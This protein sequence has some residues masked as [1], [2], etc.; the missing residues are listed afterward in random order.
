MNSLNFPHYSIH[1]TSSPPSLDELLRAHDSIIPCRRHKKSCVSS[2][3]LT[4]TRLT[5]PCPPAPRPLPVDGRDVVAPDCMTRRSEGREG[6][7]RGGRGRLRDKTMN[8][9]SER[10]SVMMPGLT[11][12]LQCW[13]GFVTRIVWPLLKENIKDLYVE[14]CNNRIPY[15]IGVVSYIQVA[16][17]GL[18]SRDLAQIKMRSVPRFYA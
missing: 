16:I 8:T 1:T 4:L 15:P 12:P 2:G 17:H 10:A 7:G 5:L 6:G 13:P 9:A 14:W 18:A 11:C 3:S